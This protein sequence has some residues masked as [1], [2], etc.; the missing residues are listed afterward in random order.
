MPTND[1]EQQDL[2]LLEEE[3]AADEAGL[4]EMTEE[5]AQQAAAFSPDTRIARAA[6]K[7][8]A[9]VE[10]EKDNPL[11]MSEALTQRYLDMGQ[12]MLNDGTSMRLGGRL[13]SKVTKIMGH[14]PGD[15][16]IHTGE[17]AAG[18]ADA[19]DA[20][21]FAVGSQDVYF[22]RGQ[23]NPET[24]EGLGVLV[25]EL[26]HIA[27][28]QVGAAFST[29]DGGAQYSAAEERAENAERFAVKQ[30]GQDFEPQ[31]EAEHTGKQQADEEA[32]DLQ[33]LEDAV[34]KLLERNN[35]RAR[36]RSGASGKGP[37]L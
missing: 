10:R 26:T 8:I 28:N 9:Q 7:A 15:V 2:E 30:D 32:I 34:A 16:R 23:F 37:E 24:P 13:R 35:R 21:A 25:H 31:G 27:D 6:S 29:K 12:S 36:D 19:L 17:R 11:A 33:Q 14:D 3:L 22:G 5:E 20:R 18:A 4:L 1:K